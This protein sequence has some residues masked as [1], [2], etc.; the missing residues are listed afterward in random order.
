MAE[1]IDKTIAAYN[2][3]PDKYEASTADMTPPVEFRHFIDMVGGSGKTVLDAGCAFGRDSAMFKA[4]GL[5]PIGIDLSDG[6]LKR[7]RA[8]HPDIVFKKMDV[9]SLSFSDER[10]DGVWSHAVLLHLDDTDLMRALQEFWR[11]LKPGGVAFVSFKKGEGTQEITERFSS[12][13][14]RFFNFKIREAM[15]TVLREAG[16]TSIETYYVNEREIFGPDKRDLDWL[17]CFAVKPR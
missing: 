4:E 15:T 13:A 11:V 2:E 1:Y 10:F 17:N 12:N 3:S 9:R 8:V 16:F 14:A 5:K 7:A 6:L